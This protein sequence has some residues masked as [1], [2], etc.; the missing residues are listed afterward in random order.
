[1][2][3][4][5]LVSIDSP[6]LSHANALTSALLDGSPILGLSRPLIDTLV[7]AA[8]EFVRL[9]DEEVALSLSREVDY[10]QRYAESVASCFREIHESIADL[11]GVLVYAELVGAAR[12]VDVDA[13]ERGRAAHDAAMGLLRELTPPAA[14]QHFHRHLENALHGLGLAWKA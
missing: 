13:R 1:M 4:V 11:V 8:R 12:K 5:T 7:C 3:L 9:D 2:R 10:Q 6:C 14:F